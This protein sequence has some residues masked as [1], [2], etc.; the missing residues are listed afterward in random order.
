MSCRIAIASII[1]T[2][3]L[4][5]AVMSAC[6][7][8]AGAPVDLPV[9]A[10]VNEPA[11]KALYAAELQ[12]YPNAD[13]HFHIPK[14]NLHDLDGDG[15]PELLVSEN[16][17]HA[18]GVYIFTVQNGKL[19]ELG[20]YGSYGDFLY[21]PVNQRILSC[22]LGQG[23]FYETLYQLTDGQMVE[24]ITFHNNE[25]VTED[26]S[27]W[28]YEINDNRVTAEE[29]QAEQD[30][31]S[32]AGD[33]ESPFARKYEITAK[34]INR[35]F[36]SYTPQ[37]NTDPTPESIPQPALAPNPEPPWKALY[38]TELQRHAD[39]YDP[40]FNLYDL[41]GDGTPEL[42]MSDDKCHAAGVDIFMV[43][44]GEL[45]ALGSYGSWGEF[46]YDPASRHIS[47]CYM[48]QGCTEHTLY[49]MTGGQMVKLVSFY[50]NAGAVDDV[51]DRYY[52]I[53]NNRVTAE[54][55][56]AERSKYVS[57]NFEAPFARKHTLTTDEIQRVFDN[58]TP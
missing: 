49:Q 2:A 39:A 35:V 57:D 51:T 34:E 38:A 4:C 53:D 43:R 22:F 13:T 55:Y 33:Y 7:K 20:G 14:F 42:L 41:D 32:Y 40:M 54:E 45:L 56:Q 24:L 8:P 5:M 16:D 28:Y 19:R 52:E 12:R 46:Q 25:G 37:L 21:D 58:Y 31:Y 1:T 15:T 50:D 23:Y 47:S 10:R 29:Y 26:E 9:D 18:N 44:D 27:E 11:W 36:D 3:C 17:G 30:R 6:A 48:G